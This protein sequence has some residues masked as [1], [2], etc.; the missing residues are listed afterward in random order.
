MQQQRQN[1]IPIQIQ[2]HIQTQLSEPAEP[3]FTETS[4]ESRVREIKFC[5]PVP[6]DIEDDIKTCEI[7]LGGSA[8]ANLHSKNSKNSSK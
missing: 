3:D 2:R 6:S 1:H 7:S 8:V 4:L 5:F